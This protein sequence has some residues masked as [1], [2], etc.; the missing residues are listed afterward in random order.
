MKIIRVSIFAILPLF[1]AIEAQGAS[2][3]TA[4]T[5]LHCQE[6]EDGSVLVERIGRGEFREVA[7]A[8]ALSSIHR[9]IRALRRK[10]SS[11]R[12][13]S[14]SSI[15]SKLKLKRFRYRRMLRTILGCLQKGVSYQASANSCEAL[16][17]TNPEHSD[18]TSNRS[19][20]SPR[21]LTGK[22]CDPESS[23]IVQLLL[24]DKEGQFK[25]T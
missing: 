10:E 11:A 14:S 21:I 20:F 7:A 8:D 13:D 16:A 2:K 18:L 9:K 25:G 22:T 19:R 4:R 23:P 15:Q 6:S 12:S 3:I 1:L 17:S 5:E 24:R